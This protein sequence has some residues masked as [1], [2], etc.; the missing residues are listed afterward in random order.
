MHNTN[1]Q[2]GCLEVSGINKILNN[3][4]HRDRLLVLVSLLYGRDDVQN[5]DTRNYFLINYFYVASPLSCCVQLGGH[6]QQ[7]FNLKSAILF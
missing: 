1:I 3:K 4:K 5:S 2:L 7:H 6:L